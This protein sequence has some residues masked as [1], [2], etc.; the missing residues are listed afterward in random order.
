[1]RLLV[2][3]PPLLAAALCPAASSGA[4]V[5]DLEK[6]VRA[7]LDALEA[8]STFHAKHL[9]TGREIAVRADEPVNTVSV[10]KLPVM[11]LAYRDVDA[12]RLDLA[13]RHVIVAEDLRRG[14]GVLQTFAVGL[15]P[16]WHDLVTQMITTSDN[17]AT[18][19]LI[20]RL[21]LA[22]V[23]QMLESLGYGQTR[24]D[25]TIAQLFRG[26]WELLDPKHASLTDPEVFERGFP[27]EAPYREYVR[28]PKKWFGRTTAREMSRLLEQLQKGELAK[29]VSTA[30]MLDILDEQVYFSR[31][32]QRIRFRVRIGH[33]TGD[34]PPLLGNDVGILHARSGPIVISAFTNDNRGSFFDLE[35]TLGRVAEDVLDA[36]ER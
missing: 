6:S 22:R 31:L 10:I 17:T 4:Q 5:P 15:N 24:L 30:A 12:G 21:G 14:T 11:I 8:T 36:W 7:R 2:L 29:P 18:D 1:M 28:D 9:P 33:K 25:M 16:T 13:E 34:W 26:V 3:A 35:A 32:P 27:E 19:I 23:N 20:G